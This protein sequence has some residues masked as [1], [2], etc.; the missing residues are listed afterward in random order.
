LNLK[1]NNILDEDYETAGYYKPWEDNSGPEGNYYFPAAGCNF[2]AGL[3][4]GF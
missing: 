4:L 1:F 3:R 2:V